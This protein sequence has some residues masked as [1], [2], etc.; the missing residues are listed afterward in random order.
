MRMR[1][2]PAALVLVA[3]PAQAKDLVFWNETGHEF[4]GVFLA[5]AGTT[6][7]GPNQTDNDPDHSVAADERLKIT[8]IDPGRYDV[9]LVD[10]AGKTCL[11]RNVEAKGSGRVAFAIGEEQLTDCAP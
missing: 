3:G 9:R 7:F 11:V 5:P 1:W 2:L 8:G 10:K 6:R 4:T